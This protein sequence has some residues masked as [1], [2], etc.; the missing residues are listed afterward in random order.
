[1]ASIKVNKEVYWQNSRSSIQIS[2][3]MPYG[4]SKESILV[5][6]IYMLQKRSRGGNLCQDDCKAVESWIIMVKKR[7][8]NR[9]YALTT[10]TTPRHRPSNC[11]W[12]YN[13][14]MQLCHFCSHWSI[15]APISR[16]NAVPSGPA[17]FMFQFLLEVRREP[18]CLP[19]LGLV[20]AASLKADQVHSHAFLYFL[21]TSVFPLDIVVANPYS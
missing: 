12:F 4:W 14:L 15:F 10:V 11:A 2:A 1:M 21:L 20:E 17:V 18:A 7:R 19:C 13:V 6:G 16:W 3:R 5:D 8:T 9:R